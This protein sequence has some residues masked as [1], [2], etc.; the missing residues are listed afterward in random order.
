M[1][2][3]LLAHAYI[4]MRVGLRLCIR[5]TLFAFAIQIV[6]L[7]ISVGNAT[8][9]ESFFGTVIFYTAV[10]CV[11][12]FTRTGF[13]ANRVR[14]GVSVAASSIA[15]AVAISSVEILAGLLHSIISFQD[16]REVYDLFFS[17]YFGPLAMVALDITRPV[18][19]LLLGISLYYAW[20]MR[21]WIVYSA[22]LIS[23]ICLDL[24]V[25]MM[26]YKDHMNS[27]VS[28]LGVSL[29]FT[30]LWCLAT[31]WIRNAAKL[32][33]VENGHKFSPRLEF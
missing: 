24:F 2:V 4:A 3:L 33:F 7:L 29:L 12:D 23:H 31:L 18:D 5:A 9:W 17:S 19:H 15:F 6:A 1:G 14:N 8:P 22:L 26:W 32:Y 13:V 25:D 21:R 20:L 27:Y 11:E 28:I 30:M 16:Q 10:L